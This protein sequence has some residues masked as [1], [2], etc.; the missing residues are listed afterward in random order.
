VR[1]LFGASA[2]LAVA[3]SV[4]LI[5]GTMERDQ[6]PAASIAVSAPAAAPTP[7]RA[8]STQPLFA[9]PFD[10][11]LE[12]AGER[13]RPSSGSARVDRIAMARA[14]EFRENEFSRWGAR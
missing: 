2:A 11:P 12:K 3:A 7:Y 14:S 5:L 4:A 8:R 1:V 6:A 9:E 13:S 10:A